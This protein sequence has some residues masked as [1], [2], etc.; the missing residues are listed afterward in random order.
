MPPDSKR[1]RQTMTLLVPVMDRSPA[2]PQL[3]Y[4][5]VEVVATGDACEASRALQGMRLLTAEAPRQLPLPDCDRPDACRCIYRH[6]DDRRQGPR[7]ED[8][9]AD[10]PLA[11]LGPERRRLRGRRESDYD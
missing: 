10:I 2:R 3:K 1:G 4:R 8:E 5:G 9:V 6:F 11:H 7:R